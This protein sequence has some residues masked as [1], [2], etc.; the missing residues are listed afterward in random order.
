MDLFA[1]MVAERRL[2]IAEAERFRTHFAGRVPEI[3]EI[4][5]ALAADYGLPYSD[6]SDAA[7]RR[8]CWA[9]FRQ[10]C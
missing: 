2:G 4:L 6:L 9:G 3:P 8:N 7:R 1:Q 10:S 5:Q